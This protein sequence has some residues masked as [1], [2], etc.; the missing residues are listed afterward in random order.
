MIK[1]LFK[2]IWKKKKSNFLLMLEIFISFLIFFAVWSLGV[3]FY[4]NYKQPAGGHIDD[5]WAIY[6]Q[7]DSDSM[8]VQKRELV[9][10]K[11]R[12]FPQ[13]ASFAFSNNN[14]PFSFSSNNSI[15][16]YNGNSAH[17][18]IMHAEPT[19]KEVLDLKMNE[20]RWLSPGDR[21]NKYPAIVINK[22]LKEMLFGN[23][24]AIGKIVGEEEKNKMQIIGVVENFK[25]ESNYNKVKPCLIGLEEE[26]SKVCLV[27]VKQDADIAFEAKLNKEL[28]GLGTGWSMEVQHMDNMKAN[29]NKLVLIPLLI[30]FIV[31]SFLIFNVALGLFGVLFQTINRRKGEIGLRRALGATRSNILWQFVDETI[32][33]AVFALLLGLFFTIQFPLLHVFDVENSTYLL[34]ILLSV[35]SILL[36]VISCALLPSRQAASILPAIALHEE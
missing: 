13:V 36:L 22:T 17:S 26:W 11:L 33:I 31:C 12:S 28:T 10:Q 30:L 25:Y 35:N 1:H 4:R 24:S 3:Y 23:E 32:V 34:A 20:G 29:K 27:K 19:M 15:I 5:V 14:V 2:L 21:I 8:R 9:S 6:C 18:E 7:F 16:K